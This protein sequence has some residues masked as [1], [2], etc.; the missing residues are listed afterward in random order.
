MRSN[1]I[2]KQN[3]MIIKKEENRIENK[4]IFDYKNR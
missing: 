3:D 4:E 1:K 2:S